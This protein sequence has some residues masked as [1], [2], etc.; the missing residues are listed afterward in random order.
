MMIEQAI[1]EILTANAAVAALVADRVY[2]GLITQ[3]GTLPAIAYQPVER[4]IVQ[5]LNQSCKLVR[6]RI[7][8]FSVTRRQT[9]GDYTGAFALD[10]A[11]NEALNR[12][13]GEVFNNSVSPPVDSITIQDIFAETRGLLP[14][15]QITADTETR[16]VFTDFNVWGHE[17]I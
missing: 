8:V 17:Q 13:A 7:R 11:V 16:S 6:K 12:F 9:G 5:A 4:E 2:P 1:Y 3:G 14:G 10:L 15:E